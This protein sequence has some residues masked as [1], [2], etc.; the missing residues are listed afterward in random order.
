[1]PHLRK[2]SGAAS[3]RAV[4]TSGATL[5]GLGLAR[6]RYLQ[7]GATDEEVTE[8]L[9]G[10]QLVPQ[11]DIV[12]TRGM[13]IA[14]P[15]DAVWPWI[16]QLGQGRGGFYTYDFLENL[17]GCD[18]HS[19]DRVV[20]QW[21]SIA[22]GDEVKLHPEVGLRVA[23][24]HPGAALVLRGGIPMGPVAPPYDFTWAFVVRAQSDGTARLV[25]RERYA[26]TRWWSSML[27]EPVQLISFVMSRRMLR[28]IKDRAQRT[29][30]ATSAPRQAATAT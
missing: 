17:V 30:A 13:T 14:A 20:P 1:M 9:P 28:G 22:V 3:L 29:A 7:W 4:A 24:V 25:V 5:V 6:R 23:L 16:A 26:Y 10:D 8:A 12:A 15:P 18:M 2:M 21:Q 19:A 27:V 11:A